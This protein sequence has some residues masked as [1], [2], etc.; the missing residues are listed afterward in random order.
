[1]GKDFS[2]TDRVAHQLQKEI[3]LILQR[4]IKDPRIGMVTVSD[5]QISRDLAYA[6]VF[7][8]F[9]TVDEQAPT[10]SLKALNEASGYIRSLVGKAIR[11]R[12]TPELTFVFDES[13]TEGMRISN[14]VSKAVRDDDERRGDDEK[15]EE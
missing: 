1:M 11:L 6:K 15:G 7:V 8:T 13:L 3:A 5:V 10:E 9:L 2:R 14:L 12:V 4:E